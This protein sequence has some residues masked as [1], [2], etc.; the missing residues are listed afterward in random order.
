M[1][2]NEVILQHRERVR[3]EREQNAKAAARRIV[4]LLPERYAKKLD[5]VTEIIVEEFTKAGGW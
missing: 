3:A 5:Q 2:T 4:A 1:T